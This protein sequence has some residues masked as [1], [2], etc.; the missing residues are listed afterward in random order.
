MPYHAWFHLCTESDIAVPF[1]TLAEAV[2]FVKSFML[3]NVKDYKF[4]HSDEDGDFAATNDTHDIAVGSMVQ[5]MVTSSLETKKA[6]YGQV[7]IMDP[8]K[9][10]EALLW[11]LEQQ[12]YQ[13]SIDHEHKLQQKKL[14]SADD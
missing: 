9:A 13:A 10:V 8:K 14:H 7:E 11:R 6:Y 2:T 1:D 4:I 5:A 12:E 3:H